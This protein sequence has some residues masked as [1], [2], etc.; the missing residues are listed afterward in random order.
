VR[1][2]DIIARAKAR[3]LQGA[4]DPLWA[5]QEWGD[6]YQDAVD[7]VWR[8][9]VGQRLNYYMVRDYSITLGSSEYALPSDF[10]ALH[11]IRY[12]SGAEYIYIPEVRTTE[13]DRGL[14]YTGFR[15]VNN[16]IILVNWDGTWPAT[17]AID[18]QR[19]P[20]ELT[21]WAGTDDPNDG[22]H[23]PDAPLNGQTGARLLAKI[24]AAIAKTKD[25]QAT[26]D[27]FALV[28]ESISS[29]VDQLGTR[30]QTEPRLAGNY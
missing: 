5:A 4:D 18:Y 11:W 10:F 8:E 15:L 9:I 29:F 3:I 28:K 16:S 27:D 13:R 25:G 1:R 24:M 14:E 6:I 19:R 30:V 2:S 17:V 21:D 26:Q 7:M 23:D 12:P 20:T 22:T